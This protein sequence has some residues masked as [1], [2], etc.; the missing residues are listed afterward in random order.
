MEEFLEIDLDYF[1]NANNKGVVLPGPE[2]NL[3]T[4]NNI[5]FYQSKFIPTMVCTENNVF[6]SG[7][8]LMA[9]G[10][11]STMIAV[12]SNSITSYDRNKRSNKIRTVCYGRINYCKERRYI[13][14]SCSIYFGM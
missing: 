10:Y 4:Q 5:N 3:P 2:E 12:S 7:E 6:N 9:D 8:R 13:Y 14:E 11:S 1:L